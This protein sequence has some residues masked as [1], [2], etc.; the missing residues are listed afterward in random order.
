VRSFLRVWEDHRV[1]NAD[2]ICVYNR[3][4]ERHLLEQL[5]E[6]L[7]AGFLEPVQEGEIVARDDVPHGIGYREFRRT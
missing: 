4:T 7:N 5:Y 1:D 3:V 2:M 6:N